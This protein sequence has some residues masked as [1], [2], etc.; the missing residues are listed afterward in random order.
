MGHD[1]SGILSIL[2]NKDN[3]EVM[4]DELYRPADRIA[5]MPITELLLNRILT[6]YEEGRNCITTSHVA[7]VDKEDECVYS[8]E[9]D[10]YEGKANEKGRV[11]LLESRIFKRYADKRIDSLIGTSL[12]VFNLID[13]EYVLDIENVYDDVWSELEIDE[14]CY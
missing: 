4:R 5:G 10:I 13:G 7:N 3:I 6:S 2:S 11:F 12:L 9:L 1:L 14:D 8:L